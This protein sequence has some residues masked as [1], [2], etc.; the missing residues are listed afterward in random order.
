MKTN[1]CL[2]GSAIVGLPASGLGGNPHPA[3]HP[4]WR[5]THDGGDTWEE[6]V[7]FA[8]SCCCCLHTIEN[9]FF[10][11]LLLNISVHEF[12][13]LLVFTSSSWVITPFLI[14]KI[15]F[16]KVFVVFMS[17]LLSPFSLPV[18][19]AAVWIFTFEDVRPQWGI[20]DHRY[21]LVFLC[22]PLEPEGGVHRRAPQ[23]Q[24]V[25]P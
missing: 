3:L 7:N 4:P 14:F 20:S 21:Q 25:R 12:S 13:F 18:C 6:W 11:Y 15:I 24:N 5:Q 9:S 10:L 2:Q 23:S 17:A 1:M 8:L 16:K 19:R 22:Q